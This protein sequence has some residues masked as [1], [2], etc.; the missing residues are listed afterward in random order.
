MSRGA[1]GKGKV[2]S[3]FQ[4]WDKKKNAGFISH[5]YLDYFHVLIIFMA[6]HIQYLTVT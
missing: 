2:M 3:P 5:L 4:T 1:K 6:S